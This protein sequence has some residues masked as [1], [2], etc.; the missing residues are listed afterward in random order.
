M[1]IRPLA[2]ASAGYAIAAVVSVAGAQT[3][4]GGISYVDRAARGEIVLGRFRGSLGAADFDRDGFVDLFIN[5]NGGAIKRVFR[6]VPSETVPGGRT[7]LDV[8]AT[9]RGVSDPEVVNTGSGGVVLFDYDNDGYPDIYTT[10]TGVG[11]AGLLLRNNRDWTFT[12]VTAAAGVRV[13]GISSLCASADDVDNDGDL[14]LLIASSG[15]AGRALTLLINNADGTFTNRSSTLPTVAFSGLIYAMAF[16]DY[17]HDGWRDALV[18]L[19]A[20]RPLLLRNVESPTGGRTFAD[21]TS[22]SGFT[23]VGPAPMGIALGDVN[24][25]GWLDVAITDAVSGT[26]YE[27]RAGVMTRVTPYTT[28]F[29]WGTEYLD[30]NNDGWVENYQ[31]GSFGRAAVDFI[32][33]NNGDGTFTDARAG[34]NTTALGSQYCAKLDFDNDGRMDIITVNP[35]DFVSVYHN[36][37]QAP[38]NWLTLRLRGGDGVNTDAAGAFVRVVTSAGTRVG[39][40]ALGTSY[41]AT[42]DARLH[43]G[44]GA[45]SSVER[46]E[47]VWPRAG[48]LA[49]RT[50]VFT[51]PFP[52]NQVVTLSPRPVCLGDFNGSG[53]V[54]VADVFDYLNA[55]FEGSPSSD[56][57]QTPGLTAR[58]V[59]TFLDAWFSGC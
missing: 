34:L 11:G 57:D 2:F 15:G 55:W 16:N 20:G 52:V 21:V 27:N 30:A 56:V 47:V 58:D 3:S 13:A 12:N 29:G 37:A 6:N 31:A 33:R 50:E 38:G 46:V 54:S 23:F 7:F 39:E 18:L 25:D 9:A 26:Y 53:S 51:G 42:D 5:D 28:F 10:G 1:F 8:S 48:T 35:S 36:V 49:Q 41:S 45:M 40:I 22:A 32:M 14:D 19:N 59:M 24:N 43:F 17:D 4:V 44:L